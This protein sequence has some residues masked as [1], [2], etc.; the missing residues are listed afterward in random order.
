MSTTTQ[1]EPKDKAR[2][3]YLQIKKVSDPHIILDR[4]AFLKE[5]VA[6]KNVLDI[7][8]VEHTTNNMKRSDWMHRHI[9]DASKTCLGMDYDQEEVL[10]LSER[11]FN[12]AAADATN[13]DLGRKFDVIVAGEVLEHL[14]DAR[15]FF[16]SI[17]RHLEKNGCLI[18]T[19]PNANS[20]NYFMQN[21]FLGYEADGYDHTAFYTPLTIFNLLRKCGFE[22]TRMAYLQPDTAGHHSSILLRALI[23]LFRIIQIAICCIRPSMSRA[24]GIVAR[25]N[26]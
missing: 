4:I 25:V 7:G 24:I 6:R 10:K 1:F 23:S 13:F 22:I 11:G 19:V 12:V 5:Y 15:G 26:N 17:T 8:C 9:C 21:L 14:L 3:F 2:A 16:A 20:L 18:L